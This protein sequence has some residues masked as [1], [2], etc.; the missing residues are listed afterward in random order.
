MAAS[1]NFDN[2]GA[3][4]NYGP[5]NDYYFPARAHD[6]LWV[7]QNGWGRIVTDCDCGC[8]RPALFPTSDHAW[9]RCV[10]ETVRAELKQ[11]KGKTQ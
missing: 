6:G 10:A 4:G 3:P 9:E 11:A 8:G 5:W 1:Y 7:A 2:A